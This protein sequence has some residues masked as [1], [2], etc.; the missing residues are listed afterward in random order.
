MAEHNRIGNEGEQIAQAFLKN[1]G[2][3]ILETNWR[4]QKAELDI[5]ATYKESLVFIEVKTRSS[6]RHGKP[7][8]AVTLSKQKN[9]IKAANAYIQENAIELESRFDVVSIVSEKDSNY[10]EHI[11]EAFYPLL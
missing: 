4:F 10:I 1:K 5:I 11:E 7:E 8:E 6:I 3:Q 9:L 2:Y